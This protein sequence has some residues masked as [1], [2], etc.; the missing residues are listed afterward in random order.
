MLKNFTPEGNQADDN[1]LYKQTRAITQEVINTVDDKEFTFQ[2]VKNA[3]ESMREKGA[4]GRWNIK[5][6]V[7]ESGRNPILVHNSNLQQVPQGRN[8]PKEVEKS[9]DNTDN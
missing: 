3:V 5:R 4:R 8:I 1:E 7:Q 9:I 2:E 6:S